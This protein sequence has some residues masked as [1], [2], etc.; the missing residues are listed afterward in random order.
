M[1][2]EQRFS[3]PSEIRHTI[4][5][6]GTFTL[7]AVSGDIQIRGD[8]G[9]EAR[10]VASDGGGGGELPLAVRRSEGGLHIE[11]DQKGLGF[12]GRGRGAGIDFEIQVP[13][14]ARVEIN[15][16]SSDIE[17][18]DLAGEQSYRSVS[19][20]VTVDGLGGRVSLT[21]VSGDAEV[22]SVAPLAANLQ[23]TSGDLDLD[24]PMLTSLQLRTVSGDANVRAGFAAG[25]IHAVESVSGDVTVEPLSGLTVEV[26]RGLDV[27]SGSGRQLVHGDGAARLRF[28]SLS[29][30]FDLSGGESRGAA[31]I[32]R[33]EVP[34]PE[35]LDEAPR[36]DSLEV[37]RALE[38][39]EIDVEEATRRL[40]GVQSGG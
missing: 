21:T 7:Q 18:R 8:D 17:A 30:D 10:V 22:R 31:D 37:L 15:G 12:L 34:P 39:G 6:N 28:R 14:S 26:K 33:E 3:N 20:D 4:G 27:A 40:E 16:V 11:I 35:A 36:E 32:Q 13:R 24:A 25:P 38:R 2:D 5:A 29:G 9:D 1:T 19:G 23:T